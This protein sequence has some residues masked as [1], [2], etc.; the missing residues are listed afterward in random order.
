SFRKR[1]VRVYIGHAP[2]ATAVRVRPRVANGSMKRKNSPFRKH[3]GGSRT[4][5]GW[6]A[7]GSVNTDNGKKRLQEGGMRVMSERMILDIP[8]H[9]GEQ[10]RVSAR[11]GNRR[12]EEVLVD[13]LSR[14]VAEPE[15]ETLPDMDV[16]R[17]CEA[18][19]D[20]SSQDALSDLLAR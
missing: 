20:P 3:E 5:R 19:L 16:L 13:W 2:V 6:L 4:E 1:R 18:T 15:V 8:E 12:V 9:V 11:V 14:V 10:A 17:L 7:S